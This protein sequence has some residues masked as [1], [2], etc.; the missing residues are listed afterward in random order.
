VA[1]QVATFAPWAI[2]AIPIAI[3]SFL[4]IDASMVNVVTKEYV[5]VGLT[6]PATVVKI[7]PMDGTQPVNVKSVCPITM[8]RRS[9]NNVSLVT[10]ARIAIGA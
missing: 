4:V 6:F 9:V 10:M 3:P 2:R 5:S 7:V 1:E 8:K